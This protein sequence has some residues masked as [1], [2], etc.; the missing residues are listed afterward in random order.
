MIRFWLAVRIRP[1]IGTDDDASVVR[2]PHRISEKIAFNLSRESPRP[3]LVSGGG[4]YRLRLN[5]T[6]PRAQH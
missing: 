1:P 6:E 3:E 4:P 5:P 2:V